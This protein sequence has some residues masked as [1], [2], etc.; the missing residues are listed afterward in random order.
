MSQPHPFL[1]RLGAT[2]LAV[3]GQPQRVV[4]EANRFEFKY[5]VPGDRLE[6]LRSLIRPHMVPDE[7][8]GGSGGQVNTSLYLD[9]PGLELFHDHIESAPN[10][11]KLR[12]RMYGDVPSGQAFFEIKRKVK[13]VTV[14][15]RAALEESWVERLLE[16][17]LEMPSGLR[18]S[19]RANLEAFLCTQ[20]LRGAR[21]QLLVRCRREAWASRDAFE[22]VRLTLDRDIQARPQL[23]A[24]LHGEGLWE[25]LDRTAQHGL[26]GSHVLLELKFPRF[27]PQWMWDAVQ[28]LSLSRVSYSKYVSGVRAVAARQ[29]SWA[30]HLDAA[31]RGG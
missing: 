14:K 22:D 5:W 11:F 18:S 15:Q 30:G 4:R 9:T 8:G 2:R 16:G 7:Q 3:A 29:Q 26:Q 12:V 17:S 13:A 31:G 28:Q 27:A 6:A 10:R 19:T 25:P 1:E 23:R 24:S 20:V 21:P